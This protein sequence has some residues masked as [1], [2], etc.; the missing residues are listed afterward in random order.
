MKNRSF[1]VLFLVLI[2][3]SFIYSQDRFLLQD[4]G[5]RD[6]KSTAM[7]LDTVDNKIIIKTL[8]W[9]ED[10]VSE[11]N[12]GEKPRFEFPSSTSSLSDYSS[13]VL[14]RYNVSSQ[15]NTYDLNSYG[16][17]SKIKSAI[18]SSHKSVNSN[19]LDN[20]YRTLYSGK[21]SS[22]KLIH[23]DR[24]G[25]YQAAVYYNEQKGEFLYKT[26]KHRSSKSPNMEFKKSV[27]L[28]FLADE[29]NGKKSPYESYSYPAKTGYQFEQALKEIKDELDDLDMK[30]PSSFAQKEKMNLIQKLSSFQ[31]ISSKR[32]GNYYYET[33]LNPNT[34]EMIYVYKKYDDGQF[35][36]LDEKS[37]SLS[38]Q[39]SVEAAREYL[40]KSGISEKESSSFGLLAQGECL[41]KIENYLD[42]KAFKDYQSIT[43]KLFENYLESALAKGATGLVDN[44]VLLNTKILDENIPLIVELDNN[45]NLKDIK[46][47]DVKMANKLGLFIT[48]Q[49][50]VNGKE[51]FSIKGKDDRGE[52]L[53]FMSLATEE[54]K[55]GKGKLAVY[56]KGLKSDGEFKYENYEKNYYDFELNSQTGRPIVGNRVRLNGKISD[57]YAFK[58]EKQGSGGFRGFV[59]GTFFG[60]SGR[61]EKVH[62][63]IYDAAKKSLLNSSFS[64]IITEKEVKAIAKDATDATKART[65]NFKINVN[66]IEAIASE[67]SY[68]RFSSLILDRTIK[69]LV[70]DESDESIKLIRSR[71]MLDFE[72]CLK[73]ASDKKN[74]EESQNCMNVFEVQAPIDVGREILSL[75]LRNLEMGDFDSYATRQYN[76]CIQEEYLERKKKGE[77]SDSE[78]TDKVKGCLFNA[79]ILTLDKGA[80]SLIEKELGVIAT[81]MKLT[82]NYSE[83]QMS[84]SVKKMNECLS[85][86]NLISQSFVGVQTNIAMLSKMDTDV[87]E[88]NLYKCSNHLV[89]D[90]S[91]FVAQAGVEA[92]LSSVEGITKE[93]RREISTS[94]LDNSFNRCL[95]AQESIIEKKRKEYFARKEEL[96][97]IR[98]RQDVKVDVEIPKLDPKECV[99]FIT[100]FTVGESSTELISGLVGKEQYKKLISDPKTKPQFLECF[101]DEN[102][103][104]EKELESSF[105]LEAGLSE[106]KKLEKKSFRDKYA[107]QKTASCLKDAIGWA[108]FYA[109]G[110]MVKEKLGENPEYSFIKFG[111]SESKTLGNIIQACMTQK[112]QK[113]NTVDEVLDNQEKITDECS[114]AMLKHP[115]AAQILFKPVVAKALA[116]GGVDEE[117]REQLSND[118][119]GMISVNIKDAKN[120]D[121]VLEKATNVKTT[122]MIY[123]VDKVVEFKVSE[124]F[125]SKADQENAMSDVR[126]NLLAGGKNLNSELQKALEQNDEKK[127]DELV[128][129]L[130]LEATKMIAP[131]VLEGKAKGL[132]ESGVFTDKKDA[133]RMV[134]KGNELF[135]KCFQTQKAS[136]TVD[137]LIDRCTLSVTEE[138]TVWVMDD[139]LIA[140]ISEDGIKEYLSAEEVKKIRSQLI[141][142]SMKA[143]LRSILKMKESPEKA[144]KDKLFILEFKANATTHVF[145]NMVEDIIVEKMGSD[146]LKAVAQFKKESIE[147]MNSCVAFNLNK[148]NDYYL[149]NKKTGIKEEDLGNNDECINRVRAQLTMNILPQKL[150]GILATLENV[151]TDRVKGLINSAKESFAGCSRKVNFTLSTNDY[152]DQVDGCLNETVLSFVEELIKS[153]GNEKPQLIEVNSGLLTKLEACREKII[154]NA[155]EMVSMTEEVK[156]SVNTF[157]GALSLARSKELKASPDLDWLLKEVQTCY[158]S[159]VT[160]PLIM[161]YRDRLVKEGKLAPR[162]KNTLDFLNLILTRTLNTEINGKPIEFVF[163]SENKE[164]KNS[165]SVEKV[166]K[167]SSKEEQSKGIISSVIEYEPMVLD[168][169]KLLNNYDSTGGMEGIK[170]LEKALIEKAKK[171]G[172]KISLD[173]VIDAL[174]EEPSLE[175]RRRGKI[176]L[177]DT[178]IEAIISQ[179]V[180]EEVTA[181]LKAEGVPTT[182]AWQL[183]DKAMIHRLFGSGKGKDVVNKIKAQ[184]LKPLLKGE[185]KDTA[186][187]KNL[188]NEAK[189]VLAR[190]TGNGGFT[191]RLFG[192]II[193]KQLHDTRDGIESGFWLFVKIPAA[194]LM[195]YNRWEDFTWGTPGTYSKYHL[196]NT[197]SGKKAVRYFGSNMLEPMLT[198]TLSAKDKERHTKK[199]TEYVKEATDEND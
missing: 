59:F 165:D 97:K 57:P 120:I 163:S 125:T 63:S 14:K 88:N 42:E 34:N 49:V 45:G 106:D 112:L 144:A 116:D 103:R 93:K 159:K 132:L 149:K 155:K 43:D 44:K 35:K 142:D 156:G 83:K 1:L 21:G 137:N 178:M 86:E 60:S 199:I 179:M 38:E 181:A 98:G 81:D 51:L 80:P 68:K 72:K 111:E 109:T 82:L 150:E 58:M 198:G 168:Y 100:N 69:G 9:N 167:A 123:A 158:I 22:Y 90:V 153:L 148:A 191:E 61:Y 166:S 172:G 99:R 15:Y 173:D 110:T 5:Y 96:I 13:E 62:D 55:S 147:L 136:E 78:S 101:K 141:N 164:G 121:D 39:S 175:D 186:L 92:K 89:S 135:E 24:K 146:N 8:S 71:A 197:A 41:S 187:P 107:D 30:M 196:R 4:Q 152:A 195:G 27:P 104:L 138:L 119:L 77:L 157:A 87:F 52:I 65:D 102:M 79:L 10:Q 105:V 184:Y 189:L 177:V 134:A 26:I 2:A 140:T 67:E 18:S 151:N 66:R 117:I 129:T 126:K 53:D 108:S 182:V 28:S 12:R 7:Y 128:N 16:S 3:N 48:K 33:W 94:A 32:N 36:I 118:L 160:R 91:K 19:S 176:S 127:V 193:Q 143:D 192:A 115:S 75:Q 23:S 113:L 131:K 29:E 31:L 54:V 95:A 56:V 169:L 190:D 50:G 37:F 145:E 194:G 114:T 74:M 171:N 139:R 25:R 40:E 84:E 11:I 17:Y 161:S 76:R 174:V 133:D 185:L 6:G 188:V 180:G 70:P 20:A 64:S 154:N 47:S 85:K 124:L 162:E 46:F 73:K 170:L 183:K 130:K 122:G